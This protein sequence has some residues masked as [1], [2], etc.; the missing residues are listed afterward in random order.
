ML[1]NFFFHLN[2]FTF[3]DYRNNFVLI[4]V[5]VSFYFLRI[6]QPNIGSFWTK[7]FFW[8]TL[9]VGKLTFPCSNGKNLAYLPFTWENRKF[10]LENH[11]VRTILFGNLEK[12]WALVC[13]RCNF[14][15]CSADFDLLCSGLFSHHANFIV[16]CSCT[17]FLTRWVV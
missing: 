4:C 17:R 11:M 9:L 16:L 6:A 7:M 15:T 3:L 12:I 10:R 5:F 2:P 8:M 1:V 14:S 13:R